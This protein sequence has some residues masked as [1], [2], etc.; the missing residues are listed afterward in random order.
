MGKGQIRRVAQIEVGNI[1]TNR[2]GTNSI[3]FVNSC[4]S[5]GGR[6]KLC[7]VLSSV[8][9]GLFEWSLWVVSQSC[10]SEWSLCVVSLSGLTVSSFYCGLLKFKETHAKNANSAGARIMV[11][12]GSAVWTHIGNK[13]CLQMNEY[14]NRRCTWPGHR[15]RCVH[16]WNV[17]IGVVQVPEPGKRSGQMYTAL[18]WTIIL[19][20]DGV[21][22]G[23]H[24]TIWAGEHSDCHTF[25]ISTRD[26]T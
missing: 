23:A 24:L 7:S 18:K 19:Y 22:A 21:T 12:A 11:R 1:Q 3:S 6:D 15:H 8:L 14:A 4:L 25:V 17:N 9:S 13:W 26:G 5:S 16:W 20:I 2:N 10:L